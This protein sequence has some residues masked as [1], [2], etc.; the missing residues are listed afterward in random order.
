MIKKNK[1][2]DFEIVNAVVALCKAGKQRERDL[3][4]HLACK[5]KHDDVV[6]AIRMALD[7]KYIKH[8]G[9]RHHRS[10]EPARYIANIG[11]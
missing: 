11:G 5:F 9:M 8:F 10:V 6:Q 1:F 4:N 2:V 7:L 3:T